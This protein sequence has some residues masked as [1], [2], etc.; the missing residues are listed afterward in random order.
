MMAPPAN[1]RAINGLLPLASMSWEFV[2]VGRLRPHEQTLPW[3]VE[4]MTEKIQRNGFF[5]K[6]LLVDRK[7]MTI[8]DGHHRHQA[9]LR[10]GLKRV[11]ALVFDYQ[12]DERIAVEAWPPAP[13][14]S[15]SKALV[16]QMATNSLLMKPKSSKH[17]IDVEIPQLRIPLSSLI[18]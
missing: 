7:T 10:L 5:H 6:P 9:S 3:R 17:C 18:S 2:D 13:A 8:L 12:D 11:P 16:V 14:K 1:R 15:V 4:E